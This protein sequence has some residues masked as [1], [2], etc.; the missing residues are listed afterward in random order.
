M[1]LI[2]RG[3]HGPLTHDFGS[4]I[5]PKIA[6]SNMAAFCSTWALFEGVAVFS[7][8]SIQPESSNVRHS[9]TD[10]VVKK[11]PSNFRAEIPLGNQFWILPGPYENRFYKT[12]SSNIDFGHIATEFLATDCRN[13]TKFVH[14]FLVKTAGPRPW[15][16][17]TKLSMVMYRPLVPDLMNI[18][19]FIDIPYILFVAA[20]K[21]LL[22]A[23]ICNYWFFLTR[24]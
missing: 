19:T 14:P 22:Y 12:V 2:K 10:R 16:S 1:P 18:T 20:D 7:Y 17:L 23:L 8:V 11:F 5:L 6:E 4:T 24:W 21:S 15:E 13:V 9:R 3:T